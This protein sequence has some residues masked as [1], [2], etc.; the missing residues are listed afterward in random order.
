MIKLSKTLSQ[1]V[2]QDYIKL[3]KD[4]SD[5]FTWSY[6]DLKVYDSKVIQHVIPLKEEQNPFKQKLR[7]IN[8]LLLPLIENEVKKLFDAKIIIALRFS[9]WVANLV[10]VRKKRGD[11][12]LCVYF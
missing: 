4:F 5:V 6:D 11:K 1:E 7:W 9:K 12:R 2:K 10:P 3:M 8:P